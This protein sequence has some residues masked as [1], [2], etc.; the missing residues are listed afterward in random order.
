M[1]MPTSNKKSAS[2]LRNAVC[3]A[4]LNVFIKNIKH[5]S[6][7]KDNFLIEN[8]PLLCEIKLNRSH[9]H[10]TNTVSRLRYLR[11]D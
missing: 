8:P 11:V 2:S 5:N 3:D 1:D 7:K 6:R 9:S 10:E 4:K